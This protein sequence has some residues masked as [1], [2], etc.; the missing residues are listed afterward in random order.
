ML[1]DNMDNAAFEAYSAW[2]ER[3]YILSPNGRIHY[4]GG[5]GPFGFDPDEARESLDS[6]LERLADSATR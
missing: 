2:P 1:V 4:E 6:L 5:P 3:I